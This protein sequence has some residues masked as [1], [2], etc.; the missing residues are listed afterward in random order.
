MEPKNK[1]QVQ[2]YRKNKEDIDEEEQNEDAKS[3]K[4]LF[5]ESSVGMI[6]ADLKGSVMNVSTLSHFHLK[7]G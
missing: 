1:V 6:N 5:E 3:E 2:E 4:S 7:S